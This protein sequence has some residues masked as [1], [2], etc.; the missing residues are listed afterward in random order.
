MSFKTSIIDGD[1]NLKRN[2]EK[3]NKNQKTKIIMIIKR[4]NTIK[5]LEN[6]SRR[7]DRDRTIFLNG[8]E[9]DDDMFE[10]II[11]CLSHST[12]SLINHNP[13]LIKFLTKKE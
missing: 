5:T 12:L 7:R 3:R 10:Q 9:E 11:E 13:E 2:F 1:W 6:M 8:K 4:E